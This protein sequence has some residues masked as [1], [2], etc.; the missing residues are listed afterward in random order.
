MVIWEPLTG[1]PGTL[2]TIPVRAQSG[3]TSSLTVYVPGARPENVRDAFDSSTPS[4]TS[5]KFPSG[6][7]PVNGN[8]VSPFGSATFSISIVPGMIR[9]RTVHFAYSPG[10][11]SRLVVGLVVRIT[12]RRVG[13]AGVQVASTNT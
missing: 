3:G 6:G 4:S 1:T 7:D 2:Q 5:T 10:L 8:R 13:D 11:I 12:R 9:L